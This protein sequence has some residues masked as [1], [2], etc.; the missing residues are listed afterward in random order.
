VNGSRRSGTHEAAGDLWSPEDGSRIWRWKSGPQEVPCWAHE[1]WHGVSL[2]GSG[3]CGLQAGVFG[4]STSEY[5]SGMSLSEPQFRQQQN[6]IINKAC[7]QT[8]VLSRVCHP[9]QVL[10]P[11]KPPTMGLE[12]PLRAPP[13]PFSMLQVMLLL[14]LGK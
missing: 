7:K 3:P 4:I 12:A 13:T 10:H 1:K 14:M 9:Q 6:E 5:D 11:T 8:Q 2:C